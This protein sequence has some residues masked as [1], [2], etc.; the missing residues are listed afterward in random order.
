MGEVEAQ[1]VRAHRRA[2]LADVGAEPLAKRRVQQV[3]RGVV[4]HRRVAGR[5]V[6]L[7][8]DPRARAPEPGG[9]VQADHL[10]VAHPVDVGDPAPWPSQRI[11]PES[12][13]CPPPSG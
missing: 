6:D 3:G 9:L 10:V 13:T 2:R 5:V 1:L 8:L 7:G 4:S 11:E 12:A